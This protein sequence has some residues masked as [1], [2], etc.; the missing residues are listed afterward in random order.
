LLLYY[1]FMSRGRVLI[2]FIAELA[3]GVSLYLLYLLL[4]PTYGTIAP[5]Y[6]YALAYA[7]LLFIMIGVLPIAEDRVRSPS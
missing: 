7:A 6:A 3:L 2:V 4:A 5:I 1:Y